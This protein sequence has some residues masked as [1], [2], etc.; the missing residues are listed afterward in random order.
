MF[1][2]AL[3]SYRHGST[4]WFSRRCRQGLLAGFPN[5]GGRLDAQDIGK[6]QFGDAAAEVRVLSITG[7]PQHDPDGHLL[8]NCL[9]NLF[10]GDLRL[11][12]ESNLLG[13]PGPLTAFGVLTPTLR[14]IQPP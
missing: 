9:A 10:Q 6:S 12:L 7:I 3:Q 5:R 2:I 4:T 14:E 13:N 8:L 11:S 1:C